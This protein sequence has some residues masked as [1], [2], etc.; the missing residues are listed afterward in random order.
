MSKHGATCTLRHDGDAGLRVL[1]IERDGEKYER[2]LQPT[3]SPTRVAREVL[4]DL[5]FF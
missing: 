4:A 3:D 1:C 5:N 2:T